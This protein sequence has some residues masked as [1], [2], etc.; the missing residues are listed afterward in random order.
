MRLSLLSDDGEIAELLINKAIE[1]RSQ[2]E[3]AAAE[4]DKVARPGN[5][6]GSDNGEPH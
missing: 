4:D 2:A 6:S 3:S 1:L 5:G